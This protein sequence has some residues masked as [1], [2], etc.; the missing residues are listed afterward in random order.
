MEVKVCA[1]IA[2]TADVVCAHRTHTEEEPVRKREGES[3]RG[4]EGEIS[5][6]SK[7]NTLADYRRNE[8]M[9]SV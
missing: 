1:R 2:L 8:T 7:M 5:D 4:G 3:E 9:R 6:S